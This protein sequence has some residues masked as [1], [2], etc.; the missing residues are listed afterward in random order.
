MADQGSDLA[1]GRL[2]RKRN[3][4]L[5]AS[6]LDNALGAFGLEPFPRDN[7][8]CKRVGELRDQGLPGGRGKVVASE[9]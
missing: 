5:L 6:L 4:C 9:H 7:K 8:T 3:G 2:C 1:F